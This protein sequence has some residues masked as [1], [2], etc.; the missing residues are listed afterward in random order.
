MRSNPNPIPASGN[1]QPYADEVRP[2]RGNANRRTVAWTLVLPNC[3][4][5]DRQ[6]ARAV[7]KRSHT[8]PTR[9]AVAST[10]PRFGIDLPSTKAAVW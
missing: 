6:L 8:C 10:S 9:A 7:S 1:A 2:S 3:S 5:A 4:I